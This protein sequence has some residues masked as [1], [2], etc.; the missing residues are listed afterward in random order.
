VHQSIIIIEVGTKEHSDC[1]GSHTALVVK[2]KWATEHTV[3]D[4]NS[5]WLVEWSVQLVVFTQF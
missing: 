4:T 3:A 2:F 5:A 1:S